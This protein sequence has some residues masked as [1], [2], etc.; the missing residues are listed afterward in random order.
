MKRLNGMDSGL[1]YGE[2]PN[3]HMH[4]MKVFVLRVEDDH[5]PMESTSRRPKPVVTAMASVSVPGVAGGDP[6]E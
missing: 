6:H 4:T 2:A 1:R 5:R 3:L